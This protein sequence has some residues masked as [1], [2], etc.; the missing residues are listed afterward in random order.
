MSKT[1][2]LNSLSNNLAQSYFS[3]NNYYDGGY[4]CDW[5]V[6]KA[7][8]LNVDKIKIDILKKEICPIEFMIKPLL[9][10]LDSLFDITKHTLKSLDFNPDFIKE[11]IFEIEIDNNR[12]MT[13]YHY[14]VDIN[15]RKYSS[16]K[17]V[18]RSEEKFE[19]KIK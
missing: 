19:V 7:Y 13:C 11:V 14:S 15:N 8:A 4:M 2:M 9:I 6:N 3:T 18:E 10:N 16:K 5:L 1:K 17:Y 12:W